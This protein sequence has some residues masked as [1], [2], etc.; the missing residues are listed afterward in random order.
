MTILALAVAANLLLAGDSLAQGVS[1]YLPHDK[2][3]ILPNASIM[4]DWETLIT[5]SKTIMLFLGSNDYSIPEPDLETR[6]R[7]LLTN[8]KKKADQVILVGP[9]C[10]AKSKF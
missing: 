5:K 2:E 10:H 1:P 3:V 7:V 9:P 8:L 4:D 6:L